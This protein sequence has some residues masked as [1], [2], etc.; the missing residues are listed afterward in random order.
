[1]K[2][3]CPGGIG[4]RHAQERWPGVNHAQLVL[5]GGR[6]GR[7]DLEIHIVSQPHSSADLPRALRQ[8][9]LATSLDLDGLF[10]ADPEGF[11]VR[12]VRA[13]TRSDRTAK[14]PHLI[15]RRPG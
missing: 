11:R 12:A 14:T 2:Y 10:D 5:R 9:L 8:H 15:D 3:I 6:G 7:D 4:F 13:L 1:M